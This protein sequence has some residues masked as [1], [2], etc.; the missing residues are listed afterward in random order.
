[1]KHK[2]L[3]KSVVI[4]LVAG[5]CAA[6]C[7]VM[8][9]ETGTEEVAEQAATVAEYSTEPATTQPATT[10]PATTKPA[11]TKPA[12][13]HVATTQAATQAVP[14]KTD[15]D[16]APLA[17]GYEEEPEVAARNTSNQNADS[18][19]KTAAPFLSIANGINGLDC[20]W[21]KVNNAEKYKLYFKTASDEDWQSL[22]TAETRATYSEAEPGQLYFVMVQSI[23]ANNREGEFSALKSLTYIPRAEI[24]SLSYNSSSNTLSWNRADGAN[25]YQIAKLKSG[26]KAYT[27]Y[28]TAS[29]SFTDKNVTTANAY[30]YQVRAMYATEKN[31]TA[32][33]A[34]SSVKSAVTL[35][36][37]T[38]SLANKSNGIRAAWGAVSGAKR[39]AVY[40]KAAEDSKWTTASTTNTYYPIL[41]VTSGTQY[42]VQVRP[43]AG[44]VSGTY[45]NVKGMTFIGVPDFTLSN[46]V[47]SA[48]ISWKK[49]DGANNYQIA[50]LKKGS[51]AYSYFT[52]EETSYLDKDVADGSV[53][54]YQVRAMYQTETDGTA[55]GTW[56][57][58]KLILRMTQP[59]VTLANKSNGIRAEWK[60]VSGAARYVVYFKTAS[61]HAWSSAVTNNT[62]YPILNTVS[63]TKYFVQ[64]RP[65][66]GGVYGPYSNPKSLTFLGLVNVQAMSM[67][68][69]GLKINWN[70]V[71]G[72]N[73]Y[74]IARKKSGNH[75]YEYFMAPGNSYVDAGV[76]NTRDTYAYQFRAINE[77]GDTASYGEWSSVYNLI[78]GKVPNGYQINNGYRYYYKNGVLLKNQIVGSKSEGYYLADANGVCCVSEEMHLAAEFVMNC[79]TGN[80]LN[81]K[82][83]TGFMYLA[84]NYPYKRTYDH[85]K[86]KADIPAL[87]IDMFRNKKGNCFRYAACF[88][89]IAKVCGYRSRIAVGNTGNGSPHGWAEVYMDGRWYYFDP[90]MQLPNYGF[91]DYYAYK[92]ANHPWNV[93]TSFRSEVTIRGGRAVWN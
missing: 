24:T 3:F 92:M 84:R 46:T 51:S 86:S 74:Q 10:K 55:F 29:T 57:Q 16:D 9:A 34:W 37:A 49:V 4:T 81:E 19:A 40:Y 28:T 67:S 89:C 80:T 12:T 7:S 1:M 6:P 41:N 22:V 27:Y 59:E 76:A 85:P 48:V 58:P 11:T 44:K 88:T 43:V 33:G 53:Y 26:D 68:A 87:A 15:E 73:K 13:T 31:G 2:L 71:A 30:Y 91:P 18:T 14:E 75:P 78:N 39:Y 60:A 42:Y 21:S 64:V 52:T 17:A 35:S 8:A 66:G 50:K 5:I 65:A 25:K 20:V 77:S 36:Q 72:A 90:D 82:M 63:G 32:Y 79:G 23:G 54:Y 93:K 61:A 70:A 45:S 38:V 62:Y 69:G 47:D 83:K 56:S